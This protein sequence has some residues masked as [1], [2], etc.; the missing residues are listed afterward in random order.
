MAAGGLTVYGGVDV[1]TG[2]EVDDPNLSQL[3]PNLV[4]G[5]I[6][7][8]AG[9]LKV[10]ALGITVLSGGA[11]ITGGLTVFDAGISVTLGGLSVT[12]GG[13]FSGVLSAD[14]LTAAQGVT[15]TSSGL[16]VNQ[17]GL[18]VNAMG[19]TVTG[20][21]TINNLGLVITNGGLS[22]PAGNVIVTGGMTVYGD[23][24]AT[25]IITPNAVQVSDRRLKKDIELLTHPL[26]KISQL[27]GVYF[28]WRDMS[29]EGITLDKN[30]HV[31]LIAQEVETVFPE[32]IESVFNDQYLAIRQNEL[33]PLLIEG[34]R[35]LDIRTASANFTFSDD[36]INE[37][38]S[39][40][41]FDGV[42]SH[43]NQLYRLSKYLIQENSNLRTRLDALERR[44]G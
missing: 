11:K 6:T 15:V 42:D 14:F 10:N 1:L 40:S 29:S 2:Q 38:I 39:T 30:R 22:I 12:G 24:Y 20:G 31:G 32:L 34:I 43:L 44:S 37:S 28:S 21:L 41:T 36:D 35:E 7:V 25:Q 3:N 33:I 5:G 4:T 26:E 23:F 16:K 9:G 19:L 27:R 17:G 18:T 13:V 8:T